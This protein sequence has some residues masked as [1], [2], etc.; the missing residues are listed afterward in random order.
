MSK[1]HKFGVEPAQLTKELQ[2]LQIREGNKSFWFN[3][4][5]HYFIYLLSIYSSVAWVYYCKTWTVCAG[6]TIKTYK[7]CKFTIRHSVLRTKSY[8]AQKYISRLP[9]PRLQSTSAV[10]VFCWLDFFYST[11]SNWINIGL[12]GQGQSTP[13]KSPGVGSPETQSR[14]RSGTVTPG[15]AVG[16]GGPQETRPAERPFVGPSA[17]VPRSP[18]KVYKG[19]GGKEISVTA[20]YLYLSV[21]EGKGVFEY[22]VL[23]HKI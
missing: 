7:L 5:V 10:L 12:V 2:K 6:Q 14:P 18:P 22:E 3:C 23:F 15:A 4:I 20:N 16:R 19:T 9:K 13:T 8:L 21:Q 11:F 17:T 1:P